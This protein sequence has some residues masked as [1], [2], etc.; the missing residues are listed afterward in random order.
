MNPVLAV[1]SLVLFVALAVAFVVVL[2]RASRVVA[3]NREDEAF[4]SAGSYLCDR[5]AEELGNVAERVDRVRR[6][7]DGAAALAEVLP[8]ALTTAGDLRDE[9]LALAPPDALEPLRGRLVEELERAARALEVVEHG[10]A[11]LRA[12]S[13]TTREV[14][15]ETSIK[16]GY[17]NLL[18]SREA[19]V[20]LAVDLRSGRTGAVR[21][22]S[23]GPRAR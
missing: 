13:R 8:G 23:E 6:R 7:Q 12:T 11:L 17:L 9:A 18:H 10:A 15:G 3:I 14:E 21:W 4:R 22:F 2:Q 5:A 19:I 16:R 1:A 20:T